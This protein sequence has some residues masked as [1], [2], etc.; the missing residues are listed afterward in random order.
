LKKKFED[1][2][3]KVRHCRLC[4]CICTESSHKFNSKREIEAGIDKYQDVANNS[5]QPSSVRQ[6]CYGAMLIFSK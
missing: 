2:E 1:L 3:K 6:T 5:P 4:N